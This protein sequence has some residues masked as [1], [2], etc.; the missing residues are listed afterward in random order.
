MGTSGLP[1]HARERCGPLE[2]A[3]RIEMA[4]KME[5]PNCGSS[6]N[7][8]ADYYQ[9]VRQGCNLYVSEDGSIHA[10]DWSG[11][12]QSYDD[13]CTEND[14]FVCQD[15]L[16]EVTVAD[17]TFKEREPKDYTNASINESGACEECGGRRISPEGGPIVRG[18]AACCRDCGFPCKSEKDADG[19]H[20]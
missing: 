9:A 7:F 4:K 14:R 1:M 11:D 6:D 8:S 18:C 5:C 20:A 10:D 13:G 17:W 15:C 16:W 19:F 2:A 12:E 3:E